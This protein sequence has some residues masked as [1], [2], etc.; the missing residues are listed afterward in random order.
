M[1]RAAA[2]GPAFVV[3]TG[4]DVKPLSLAVFVKRLRTALSAS[5]CDTT[6]YAG[7]SFRRGGAT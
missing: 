2:D 5:G 4:A 7:H 1:P 3:P 6:R